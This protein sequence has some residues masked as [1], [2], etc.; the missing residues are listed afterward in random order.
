MEIQHLKNFCVIAEY[1]SLTEAAKRL[2]VSQSSLSRNLQALEDEIGVPLFDR[3]GR[4]IVINNA[5]RVALRR[6]RLALDSLSSVKEDVLNVASKSNLEVN[7][8]TPVPMAELM[9]LISGFIQKYPE[10]NVRVGSMGTVYSERLKRFGPDI[11]FFA[12]SIVHKEPNYLLLGEE[13]I[14]LAVSPN[15][16]LAQEKSVRLASLAEERFVNLLPSALY[17]V[18]ADMFREAG[19]RP[20]IVLE[21][22]D[23]VRVLW[24][25]SEGIGVSLAPAITWFGAMK[26]RVSAVPISD[27]KRKSFLY[28][29]WPENKVLNHATLRFR[30]YA[31]DYFNENH[32][33]TC[34]KERTV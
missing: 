33:F 20:H 31:I 15:S 5:G 18:F 17:D 34:G 7:L 12:S 23:F 24:A 3:L 16:P 11:T 10:I 30:A 25:V 14:I 2:H 19:F 9:P 1:E 8:Y 26:D 32:G 28:L 13:E 6:A 4:K 22:Q 21:D 27:V 29:K